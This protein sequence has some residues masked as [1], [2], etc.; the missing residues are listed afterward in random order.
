VQLS[1]NAFDVPQRVIRNIQPLPAVSYVHI[2]ERCESAE[3]CA[4]LE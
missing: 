3:C 2:I 1:N 4:A